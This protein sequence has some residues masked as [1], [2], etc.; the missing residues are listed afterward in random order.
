[1]KASLCI[2]INPHHSPGYSL[3]P[4]AHPPKQNVL[5]IWVFIVQLFARDLV[6]V[7]VCSVCSGASNG[8]PF[9]HNNI[10][11]ICIRNVR[12]GEISSDNSQAS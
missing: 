12:A 9:A 5:C 11:S 3:Q 7:C 2:T 4:S 10:S 6:C 8:H 1:M